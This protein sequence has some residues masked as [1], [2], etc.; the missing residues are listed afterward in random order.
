MSGINMVWKMHIKITI[1]FFSVLVF[2]Q[3]IMKNKQTLKTHTAENT[4]TRTVLQN[5][6]ENWII[7][8][9]LLK[10]QPVMQERKQNSLQLHTMENFNC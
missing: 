9:I 6:E 4:Q 8:H 7:K 2:L 10:V 3:W 5:S 1:T